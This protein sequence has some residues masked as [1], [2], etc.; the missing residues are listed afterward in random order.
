MC[1]FRSKGLIECS[2]KLSNDA[3]LTREVETELTPIS[4]APKWRITLPVNSG[5]IIQISKKSAS[6]SACII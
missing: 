2:M 6:T 5:G 4:N 1:T 3:V